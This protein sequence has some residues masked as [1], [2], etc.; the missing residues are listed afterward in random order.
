MGDKRYENVSVR[1]TKFSVYKFIVQVD[2]IVDITHLYKY[3]TKNFG[4]CR[5]W[6]PFCFRRMKIINKIK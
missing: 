4:L 2:I 6:L 5:G 1:A 3:K